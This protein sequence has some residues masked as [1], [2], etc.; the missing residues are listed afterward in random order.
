VQITR[1]K[2]KKNADINFRDF[3]TE[4]TTHQA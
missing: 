1:T 4:M 3:L 2:I